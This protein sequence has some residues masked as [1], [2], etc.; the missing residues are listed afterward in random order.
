MKQ[1]E[2]TKRWLAWTLTYKPRSVKN[3]GAIL[4]LAWNYLIVSEFYLLMHYN[5]TKYDKIWQLAGGFT[6]PVAGWLA[7]M[8][9]GRYKLLSCSIWIMWFST[10][11]ATMSLTVD[12][13]FEACSQINA[14]VFLVLLIVM[15]TAL[16]GLQ[17]NIIQFGLDQLHDASTIE[18]KAF[19]IWHIFTIFGCG[20]T[21][22]FVLSCLSTKYEIV[23]LL[24]VCAHLTLAVI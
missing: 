22:D 24:V 17:A 19:I 21:I 18:I 1:N 10:L 11:A 4:A 20:M 23:T 15:A 8:Y 7:D 2:Q 16:G 9:I 12:Q 13:F 5:E 14:K 3:K 6:L